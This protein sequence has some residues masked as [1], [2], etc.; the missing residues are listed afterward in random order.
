MSDYLKCLDDLEH[1]GCS[2]FNF[3]L[4]T[5]AQAMRYGFD[6]GWKAAKGLPPNKV[7][8]E[9]QGVYICPK[10]GNP[11]GSMATCTVCIKYEKDNVIKPGHKHRFKV[12]YYPDKNGD[13][14]VRC[15]ECAESYPLML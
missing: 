13:G 11:I 3:R 4:N 12:V 5:P 8:I 1:H 14:S 6:F 7:T 10:C 2:D 9:R 15:E